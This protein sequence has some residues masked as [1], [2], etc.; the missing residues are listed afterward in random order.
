MSNQIVVST[1]NAL[2]PGKKVTI[3]LDV[4]YK[5]LA[6]HL[7]RINFTAAQA[8]NY[9]L[10]INGKQVQSLDSL[11][12]LEDMNTHYNRPQIAGFTTIY[13]ARPELSDSE[14]RDATGLGTR[15]IR[16]AQV[17]FTLDPLVITPDMTVVAD[18]T[19]NEFLGWITHIESSDIDLPNVGK[20]VISKMPVGNGNVWAYFM[21]KPTQDM[22]DA[23]LLR[24]VD[25]VKANV[26]ESTKE[27]LEVE[28]KQAA[29]R[30]RVPVSASYTV[31]DFTTKGIPEDA[32]QT[33]TLDIPGK[34]L[35]SVDRIS[36]HLTVA[37]AETMSVI[38]ESVGAFNG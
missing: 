19:S 3:D 37:T 14:D 27:F 5:Y 32:L 20:N 9:K 26:I 33:D 1:F 7:K 4:G 23:V 18:T 6:L 12:I 22:T 35:V 31:F 8:L 11:Q 38:T 15:D 28:Q 30:P 2:N 16:T 34:G 13:F 21:K 29:M 25:G 10:K 24:T 36:A 17:E